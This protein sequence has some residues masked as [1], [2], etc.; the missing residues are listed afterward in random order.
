MDFGEQIWG[1]LSE[2]MSFEIFT[3]LWSHVNE[4]E[5]MANIQKFQL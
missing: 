1:V 2:Q 3:P 5:K 4:N